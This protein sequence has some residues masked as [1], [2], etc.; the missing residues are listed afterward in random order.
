MACS[1]IT[2]IFFDTSSLEHLKYTAIFL[3]ITGFWY[4]NKKLTQSLERLINIRD[5]APFEELLIL[6]NEARMVGTVAE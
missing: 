3:M 4:P 1:A 2:L 6:Y 5:S